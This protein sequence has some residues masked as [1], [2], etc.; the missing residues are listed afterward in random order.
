MMFGLRQLVNRTTRSVAPTEAGRRLL[1]RLMP[2]FGDIA[3][4]VAALSDYRGRPAGHVRI[5]ASRI[6]ARTLIAPKIAQLRREHPDVL[7]ELSVDDG[8]TDIVTSGYDAG[9]RS[10]ELID[11]DMISVRI[12]PDQRFAVVGSPEYFKDHPIPVA[13]EALSDHR[14]IAYRHIT[15]G[16]IHRWT[17]TKEGRS[18]RVAIEPS[19][20]TNDADLLVDAAIDGVGLAFILEGQA[21]EQ[22]ASGALISVLSDWCAPRAGEFLY[23]PSHRQMTPAFR[24]VVDALRLS[25]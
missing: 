20:L 5:N 8:L 17:F 23:Y 11:K 10:G 7:V 4:A 22:I 25:V 15:S 6:A 1:E 13:P 24:A 12:G 18:V 16:S 14:C 3:S 21:T 9:V 19:F 2:A